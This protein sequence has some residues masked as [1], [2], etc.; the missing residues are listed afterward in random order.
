MKNAL[1]ETLRQQTQILFANIE[2]T[3]NAAD[4]TDFN[5][6]S[7]R[8]PLWKQFYHM[9]HSLDQW[10]INPFQYT[11]PA[12][13][14]TGLNLIGK[15]TPD[16]VLSKQILQEYYGKIRI[17]IDKYLEDLEP[18]LLEEYPDG[19]EFSRITLILA[20]F[21]HL[22]YHIGFIHACILKETGNMPEFI[23]IS[24]PVDT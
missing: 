4:R 20:Q 13:H 14:E 2:A 18:D 1:A 12:F 8:G 16:K 10:F 23:G 24:P 21:R 3:F 7:L 19:C 11:E 9:L 15:I 17:K 5:K 22:M 6:S